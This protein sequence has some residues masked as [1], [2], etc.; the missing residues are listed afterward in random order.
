[1]LVLNSLLH[2]IPDT[3]L[4]LAPG[5]A[6]QFFRECLAQTQTEPELVIYATTGEAK[7][8]HQPG[9]AEIVQAS[10]KQFPHAQH[11][12]VSLG[13][14]GLHAALLHVAQSQAR[15]ALV[16]LVEISL[17]YGQDEMNQEGLG[18]DGDD[19][20]G[21]ESVGFLDISRKS[22]AEIT[23]SDIVIEDCCILAKPHGM[24]GLRRLMQKISQLLVK[25]TPDHPSLV[26]FRL[27]SR[28]AAQLLAA[29]ERMVLPKL[30]PFTVLPSSEQDQLHRLS[31]KPL[32]EMV[33]YQEVLMREGKL[34]ISSLGAG[35]RFGF[36]LLAMGSMHVA[37]AW[38]GVPQ[39]VVREAICFDGEGFHPPAETQYLVFDP[40]HQIVDDA[41]FCWSILPAVID[42]AH[43]LPQISPSLSLA[44]E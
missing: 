21:Q 43:W 10:I 38:S 34:A 22:P 17:E 27:G 5:Y 1:M 14:L 40:D 16:L 4:G 24:V 28:W 11:E 25:N 15:S 31:L 37:S 39:P 23:A 30:P 6:R 18:V 44:T 29:F 26:S 12:L 7:L 8:L 2:Q 3:G 13:C 19:M 41:Y 33:Q 9:V 32:L 20:I 35:G 36:I 42:D